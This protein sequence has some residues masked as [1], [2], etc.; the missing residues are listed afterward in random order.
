MCHFG[1][2]IVLGWRYLRLRKSFLPL[3]QLPKIILI[4][5]LAQEENYHQMK[6]F[7]LKDLPAWQCKPLITKHLLFSSSWE[8]LYSPLKPQG[9]LPFI[10]SGQH[11]SFSCLTAFGSHGDFCIYKIFIQ[12]MSYVTLIIRPVIEPGREEGSFLLL[13]ST[14]KKNNLFL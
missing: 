7:Y 10:S 5:D 13:H 9:P 1:T 12:L 3:P 2:W 6:T 4:G 8:L 11:I 14:W